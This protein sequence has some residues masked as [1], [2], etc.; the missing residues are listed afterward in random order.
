MNSVN[1]LL[2]YSH[3]ALLVNWGIRLIQLPVNQILYFL[4]ADKLGNSEWRE[5]ERVASIFNPEDTEKKAVDSE[6]HHP[7]DNNGHLLR[8]VVGHTGN[9]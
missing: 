4:A 7:P 2:I 1:Y 3:R 8:F 5:E 6:E 9:L